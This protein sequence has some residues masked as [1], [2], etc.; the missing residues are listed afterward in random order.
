MVVVQPL[1]EGTVRYLLTC[2]A[3]RTRADGNGPLPG[4][5]D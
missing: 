5:L 2:A 4:V 3:R 1:G